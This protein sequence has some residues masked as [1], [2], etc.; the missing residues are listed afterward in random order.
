MLYRQQGRFVYGVAAQ[1]S[2]QGPFRKCVLKSI[3]EVERELERP[4][5]KY[6]LEVHRAKTLFLQ[7]V[8]KLAQA[9][10]SLKEIC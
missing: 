10:E 5:W 7:S 6:V 3:L 4:F 2:L 1:T 9:N 8:K